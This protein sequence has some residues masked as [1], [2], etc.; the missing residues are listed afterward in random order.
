ML[1]DAR[2]SRLQAAGAVV[3]SLALVTRLAVALR[4]IGLDEGRRVLG[5][6][7]QLGDAS[8]GSGEVGLQGGDLLPEC[9]ILCLKGSD[10]LGRCHTMQAAKSVHRPCTP[11]LNIY[12]SLATIDGDCV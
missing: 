12:R 4:C 5:A 6:V 1:L 11:S 3:L 2:G 9:R 10:V 7:L 8:E